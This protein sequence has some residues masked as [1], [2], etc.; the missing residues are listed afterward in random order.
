MMVMGVDTLS[1]SDVRDYESWH[2]SDCQADALT[3]GLRAHRFFGDGFR[4]RAV[5]ERA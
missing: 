3:L 4:R 1:D 2:S 5:I